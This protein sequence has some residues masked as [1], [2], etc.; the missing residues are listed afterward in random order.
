MS[1]GVTG[2]PTRLSCLRKQCLIRDRY[3]CVISRKLDD[4]EAKARWAKY[5][6]DS[7]DEDGL[8][9]KDEIPGFLQVAHILPHSLT[10]SSKNS[11]LVCASHPTISNSSVLCF[12]GFHH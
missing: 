10:S 5:G 4:T 3:R 8:L 1:D 6:P 12:L 9:L 7:K 2:T 11:Q